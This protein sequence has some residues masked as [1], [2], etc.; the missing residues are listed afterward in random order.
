MR[1]RNSGG[2]ALQQSSTAGGDSADALEPSEPATSGDQRPA[3]DDQRGRLGAEL[4]LV[5]MVTIWGVNFAVVKWALEAF[6]PLGFNSLRHI[7]ASLFMVGVLLRA[8]GIR[9]PPRRDVLRILCL[10]ALG[11]VV[12]QMLFIFGLDRTRAGNASLM[13]ALVPLFLLVLGRSGGERR[14]LAWAG[15]MLSVS[16]V[17]LVSGSSLRL[18]GAGTLIGDLI[19]IG[20]AGVWAIYTLGAQPLIDRH[21][22]LETT[23]WTLW[24][25]SLGLAIIGIP[26]LVAQDWTLVGPAAWGGLV[27]SSVFSIGL[28]Y[29]L[30]YQGVQKLGSART[31]VFSNL[32]PVVALT[33]GVLWLDE[34][35]TLPALLGAAM[36]VGG[37]LL[38]RS[39]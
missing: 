23:A 4:G 19:L 15:A 38:V 35:F 2:N 31:A 11:V 33:T 36:V 9:R 18:E 22:P 39:R 8:G 24:V 7:L 1:L 16:G 25:G 3:S 37:V 29:L 12:Y 6:D 17:A 20:A 32:T 5:A 27:F 21:G 26:G 34:R 14:G 28:A 10:G 30:W 13:L